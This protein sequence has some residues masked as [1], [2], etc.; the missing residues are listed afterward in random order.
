MFARAMLALS[1]LAAGLLVA[2]LPITGLPTAFADQS[3]RSAVLMPGKTTL[4]QRVITK[5]AGILRS[6]PE[7][8]ASVVEQSVPTFSVFY[9]Y[10]EHNDFLELGTNSH[11]S[12]R[13][14]MLRDSLVDWKQSI[15]VAFNNR[16]DS[17]RE[18]HFFY[19]NKQSLEAAIAAGGAG[20]RVSN[21]D[22][23]AKE[24]E[25][26]IDTSRNFYLLPI[27]DHESTYLP[28]DAEGNE[29]EV[30]SVTENAE[31][32]DERDFKA[33]VVF[34]I[35]TTISMQPYIE[36]T[37]KAVEQISRTLENSE[38]RGK[39]SFG[40]VGFRQSERTNPGIGY[41]VRNFLPL[42]VGSGASEFIAKI[43]QMKVATRP[44]EGFQEDSIGGID[45]AIRDNDWRSYKARYLILVTD[46]G[47]RSPAF[48]DNFADM[49][50]T[51]ELAGN[52]RANKI[53]AQVLHLKTPEG[54]GDHVSA[55]AKYREISAM[56][57]SSYD[58]YTAVRNG[59][60]RAFRS[61]I[62]TVAGEIL[63]TSRDISR[64]RE[65]AE[66]A[67]NDT[68]TAANI[69]RTAR[70]FQLEYV[71]SREG[72]SA[73]PFY[74]AWTVDRAFNDF[75]RQALDVRILLTKNQLSTMTENLREIVNRANRPGELL[76]ANRFFQDIQEL[77]L[78]TSNDPS[79]LN[80]NRTL[81][82]AIAEYLDD[83]P[84]KSQT[85]ALTMADWVSASAT[86]QRDIVHSLSSKLDFYERVHNN[87][88][89]WFAL[90]EDA[91][92]GEYV[93]TIS[94]DRMP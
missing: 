26:V 72:E 93:T 9:V 50:S 19:K 79:Q 76:D 21:R 55:E 71:G 3:S 4:Y 22:A 69:R 34:V 77:A 39:F 40:L 23:I 8:G 86:E 81:G 1:V 78:R 25:N 73:P 24:P 61:E 94:L 56:E 52:L 17:G 38:L 66:P 48:G 85:T 62:D 63:Q 67:A 30:A 7:L 87:P 14:W 60:L 57:G 18:R 82:N 68:S 35:D 53:R 32:R 5:P 49:L 75:R 58:R 10:G 64:N 2:A 83:L 51:G 47:P 70:A 91:A 92:P 46:A 41:Q 31:N 20:Q 89:L 59:D 80:E 90:H 15:V 84:Y 43:G 29:L 88:D 42:S 37:K 65:I 36:Q 45:L 16:A 6:A 74:R 12:T 28:G 44:T 13:G 11:G 33:A 27:L 54:G